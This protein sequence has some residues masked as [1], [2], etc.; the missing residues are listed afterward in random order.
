MAEIYNFKEQIY[1]VEERMLKSQ[2]KIKTQLE[3]EVDRSKAL[4]DHLRVDVD[5][6]QSGVRYL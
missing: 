4:I 3:M 1:R 6:L 5:E 2:S